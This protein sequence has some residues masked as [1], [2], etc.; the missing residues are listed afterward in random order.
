MTLAMRRLGTTRLDITRVG[1]GAWAIGG[2]EW[3][4]GW[5]PQ[6]DAE[7]VAT[8]LRAVELGV[9]W[10]DTAPAYGL[11]RAERVVG[12]AIRRLPAADRPLIFTKCGLVWAEG[13]R[14]ITNSLSPATIRREC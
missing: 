12:E 10:V 4:G 2:G 3:Q 13:Q 11:G 1:F 14:T 5:G 6:D 7:S 9:N 8:I